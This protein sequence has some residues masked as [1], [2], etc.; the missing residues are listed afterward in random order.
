[1]EAFGKWKAYPRRRI[2]PYPFSHPMSYPMAYTD[3][4]LESVEADLGVIC[5]PGVVFP[6]LQ[7]VA[8]PS[9]LTDMLTR[10]MQLALVSEKARSEFIVA[11]L[12]LAVRDATGGTIAILSGH[13]LDVDASRRLLG[14]CDF[15]LYLTRPGVTRF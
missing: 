15:L 13:R 6:D 11:P 1:M 5:R 8:V 7:P 9:W 3:F 12:L 2:S 14:E 10:G 4:T